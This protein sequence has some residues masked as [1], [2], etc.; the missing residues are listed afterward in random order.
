MRYYCPFCRRD[1]RSSGLTKLMQVG[2]WLR[3]C[4]GADSETEMEQRAAKRAAKEEIRQI[5]AEA[6]AEKVRQRE[7]RRAQ[8]KA[9]Q[10]AR[11]HAI[12]LAN[13]GS[14]TPGTEGS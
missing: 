12:Y 11:L 6:Q 14:T 1:R 5:K 7:E 3:I 10:Q 9:R 13:K 8:K 4:T 2:A